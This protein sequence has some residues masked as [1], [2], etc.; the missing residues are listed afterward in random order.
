MFILD[1]ERDADVVGAF[2]R[3][4][5][6]VEANRESFPTGAFRLASSE[7]YFDFTDR[8][9]PHDG[10]LESASFLEPS[11]GERSE[12]RSTE[13]T[14]RLLGA[15]HD[16]HVELH[17]PEVSAYQLIG[18]AVGPGHGDWRYDEFRLNSSGKLVHEIEWAGGSRWIIES[19]DIRHRWIEL[20]EP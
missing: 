19:S 2:R 12:I 6:Y 5:E 4:A 10:W 7:W 3:Y 15:Y 14:I 9:C 16:G 1:G 17:Y 13:L 8:R 20:K 18:P 11:N